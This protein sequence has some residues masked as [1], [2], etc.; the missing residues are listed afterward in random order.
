MRPW[1]YAFTII[2][3]L[4]FAAGIIEEY[5]AN[6][7]PPMVAVIVGGLLNPVF[8]IGFPL[9]IYWLR[10]SKKSHFLAAIDS[11]KPGSTLAKWNDTPQR[12]AWL[13]GL[14]WHAR[15][16]WLLRDYLQHRIE[17]SRDRSER[18]NYRR[19]L[20]AFD[21]ATSN[22]NV[23]QIEL[24]ALPYDDPRAFL[25]VPSIPSTGAVVWLPCLSIEGTEHIADIIRET[26]PFGRAKLHCEPI[27]RPIDPEER[28]RGFP[29]KIQSHFYPN[30]PIH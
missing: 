17:I 18:S 27:A 29:P 9:G 11:G 3:G 15:R 20:A 1:G 30:R 28:K 26:S 4:A 16:T 25:I 19:F 10:Q 14:A 12:P 21:A 7:N 8:F 13:A 2:G 23:A 5:S 6:R 22:G 24:D